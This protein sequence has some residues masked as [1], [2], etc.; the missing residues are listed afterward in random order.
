MPTLRTAQS[1]LRGFRRDDLF[2][3]LRDRVTASLRISEK[4]RRPQP[5]KRPALALVDRGAEDIPFH[6]V[7]SLRKP[8]SI[9]DHA[10]GDILGMDRMVERDIDAEAVVA[11]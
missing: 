6:R 2:G 7:F 5:M 4:V 11:P 9:A 1:V 10:E 8:R 3:F